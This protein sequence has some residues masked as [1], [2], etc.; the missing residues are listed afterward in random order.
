V[1]QHHMEMEE[2]I[3]NKYC[4][5]FLYYALRIHTYNFR[6][7]ETFSFPPWHMWGELLEL[8]TWRSMLGTSF[9]VTTYLSPCEAHE[10]VMLTVKMDLVKVEW[11]TCGPILFCGPSI[12]FLPVTPLSVVP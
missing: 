10:L 6:I 5:T 4:C 9:H 8:V 2:M 12:M 1:Q 7:T 3:Q 11:S